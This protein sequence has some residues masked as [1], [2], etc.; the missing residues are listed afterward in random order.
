MA[1]TT[2]SRDGCFPLSGQ[3]SIGVGALLLCFGL[4]AG[5]GSDYRF[6]AMGK[7]LAPWKSALVFALALIGRAPRPGSCRSMSGCRRRMP[8]LRATSQR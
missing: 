4:L 6:A 7:A 5:A 1:D 3:A 8:P 2:P